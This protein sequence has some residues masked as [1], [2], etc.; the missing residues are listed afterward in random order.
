MEKK[1]TAS[2]Q[3]L[4]LVRVQSTHGRRKDELAAFN[5][6]YRVGMGNLRRVPHDIHCGAE[7]A[8]VN[9]RLAA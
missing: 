8:Q 2:K 3:M 6:G 1:K 5:V 7:G 4:G 9:R